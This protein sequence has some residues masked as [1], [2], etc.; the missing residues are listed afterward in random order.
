MLIVIFN[1]KVTMLKYL[2]KQS[3][4]SL[5]LKDGIQQKPNLLKAFSC[6]LI[7]PSHI[8]LMRLSVKCLIL[9]S[10]MEK[11]IP[12]LTYNSS[13]K[14]ISTSRTQSTY[15]LLMRQKYLIF[16]QQAYNQARIILFSLVAITLGL[17]IPTSVSLIMK[18][19]P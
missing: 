14:I 9:K 7:R 6:L 19:Q 11:L 15:L 12:R 18:F 13:M 10:L 8:L 2:R 17:K 4:V 16:T 5:H 3:V 1:S